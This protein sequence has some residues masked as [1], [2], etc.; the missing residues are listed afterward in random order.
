[1]TDEQFN[2][3]FAKLYAYMDRRFS[4]IDAELENKAEKSEVNGIY[5]KLDHII[6]QLEKRP[7]S[8]LPSQ[9]SSIVTNVGIMRWPIT[10]G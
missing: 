6:G 8:V 3:Q 4:K 2:E 5:D 9:T 10:S 7:L 1:M